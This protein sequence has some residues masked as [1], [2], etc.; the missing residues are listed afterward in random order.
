MISRKPLD[1]NSGTSRPDSGKVSKRPTFGFD[2]CNEPTRR[3]RIVGSNIT[4]NF[5]KAVQGWAAPND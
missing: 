2:D 5:E 3:R 1:G 4:R